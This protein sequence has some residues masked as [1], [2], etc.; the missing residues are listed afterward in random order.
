[1]SSETYVI[2]G[3]LG[4]PRGVHGEIY[5]TPDT[6][7]PERFVG[8]K[9]IYVRDRQRWDK[10]NIIS[11]Q[12]ISG[13]PVIRFEEITTPQEAARM[14]NRLLAVPKSQ[15]VALPRGTYFIFDLIGCRVME[16]GSNRLI[17]LVTEVERY[18]ANDVYVIDTTSG[19]EVRCP[20]VKQFVKKV[21][22]KK[23]EITIVTT[24]WL[25][26]QEV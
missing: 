14:T 22:M 19:K 21:D 9:E 26:D 24:G 16:E 25:E 2:V 17:G 23:R 20:V 10:F 5:V 12:L 18:P 8:L 13:R 3:K 6:D 15:I 4:R 7:F 1:V 11:S